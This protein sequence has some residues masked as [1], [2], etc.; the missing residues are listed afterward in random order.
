MTALILLK[1]AA[2]FLNLICNSDGQ[3]KNDSYA[4][5]SA[6]YGRLYHLYSKM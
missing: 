3:M 1:L 5:Y 2:F 6:Q 4:L